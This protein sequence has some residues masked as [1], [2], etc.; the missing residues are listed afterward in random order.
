MKTRRLIS[1]MLAGLMVGSALSMS[2]CAAKNAEKV[3][4]T[5]NHGYIYKA[6]NDLKIV[7]LEKGVYTLHKGDIYNVR[8]LDAGQYMY[9]ATNR[10]LF[11][12]GE[13]LITNNYVGYPNKVD[14]SKYDVRCEECFFG[15]D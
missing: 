4:P 5:E 2:A 14:E 6:Y 15:K 11:E 13:E 12:C 1:V 8:E 7:V 3:Q 9:P 10:L